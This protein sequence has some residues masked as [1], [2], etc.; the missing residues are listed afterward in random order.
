MIRNKRR[1]SVW[2]HFLGTWFYEKQKG[3]RLTFSVM[4]ERRAFLSLRKSCECASTAHCKLESEIG[5]HIF[6]FK[7]SIFSNF[8]HRLCNH[9]SWYNNCSEA[10][11]LRQQRHVSISLDHIE[12]E[13]NIVF[14]W[15]TKVTF[16]L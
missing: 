1:K 3:C 11:Q 10:Q 13:T 2:E 8:L 15:V 9:S 6:F 5:N 4:C 7:T 16:V 12:P 14:L